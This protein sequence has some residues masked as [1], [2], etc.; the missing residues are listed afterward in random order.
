M[1]IGKIA[2]ELAEKLGAEIT[3]EAIQ[4]AP[5]VVKPTPSRT[6]TKGVE[7]EQVIIDR[8]DD[9][10]KDTQRTGIEFEK[11]K[12]KEEQLKIDNPAIPGEATITKD[13]EEAK[14]AIFE[15]K[16][17]LYL[18][19]VTLKKEQEL[20]NIMKTNKAKGI[21]GYDTVLDQVSVKLGRGQPFSNIEARTGAIYNRVSAPM[22]DLKESLRTKWVGL[23]QDTDLADEVLRYLKDGK[24]K[25]AANLATVK[26]ISKQ[27]EDA[28]G[29]L[30]NLRNRAGARIGTLE[31][32]ILPQSHD[33][34]K[35]VKAG[36]DEWVKYIKPRLNVARIETEQQAN[37]DE[38]LK[39]AYTNITAREA[40]R[41]P[42]KPQL[43]KAG[44]FERILH[45]KDG[46]GMIE[47]KNS[48][49]NPDVFSTMDAH[50]RQQSNEIATLQLFGANPERNFEKM[51]ELARADGMGSVAEG[52]LD[53]VWKVTTGQADGN[54]IVSSFDNVVAQV[55]GGHR[56]LQVASKLGSATIT[57]LADLSTMIIG[58]GYR[59]LSSVK[60]MG[61]SLDT[62][63]QEAVTVGKVGK[64]TE[65]ASRIGV[66]SEFAS[67]SLAN[68]RYAEVA[69]GFMQRRAENVIRASGLGA[70]TNSLR[71]GFGLELAGKFYDDFG[72]K[73]DKLQYKKM[74]EEYGITSKEWD[75]IRSTSAKE[76]RG[77][78]G[79]AA[80]AKFLDLEAVFAKDEELGFRLSE[81]ITSEMDSFVIMPTDRVRAFTTAGMRKGT[82][83]GEAA[84]NVALFKSF[85]ITLT[86]L[87]I[88]RLGA[89]NTP[90]KVGYAAAVIVA[91]TILG[92][93][94]LWAYDV[95]TGK[96]PRDPNRK[97]MVPEALAKG[98]G[99]GI[100]GDILLGEDKSR[101]GHSWASTVMGVPASTL[102]DVAKT[103][104]EAA[105]FNKKFV[106]NTYNRAKRYI[107][108]QN[109]WYTRTLMDRTIGDAVG[110]IIDPD[111]QKKI[112][113]REKALR[114]RGQEPLFR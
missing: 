109:L 32:W 47:Y 59:G 91:N 2:S 92:S 39:K 24:V 6:P 96:T 73:F 55:G 65:L 108:G 4:E 61:R 70:W 112:R 25:D 83:G 105:T 12:V 89:M 60:M 84:R 101:Y 67:A 45:F 68:S 43:A 38:I 1:P 88:N 63:L 93:V 102:E 44:E 14:N 28:A 31:D 86:M 13:I 33:K 71:V 29:T 87:H 82:L 46:E 107:P 35:M 51:K 40:V 72:K 114:L 41:A 7:P 97:A 111:R 78:G 104:F 36:F 11:V 3:E 69:S 74:F 22:H 53:R 19:A 17:N 77:K 64:N 42:G 100:F 48:F 58:A 8:I 26:T 79:K 50:I 10:K 75:I 30:K 81:M 110:N 37:I 9:I 98:G 90:T 52:H 103:A 85:P 23:S 15:K 66:V 106:P 94:A 62:L 113:R 57:S 34:L 18:K 56:A 99:L 76:I 49:G 20:T 80:P 5:K 95:A 16:R 21:S 27:W 54:D